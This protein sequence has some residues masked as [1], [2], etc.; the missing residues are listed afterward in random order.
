[1]KRGEIWTAS[2]GPDYAS[3]PRPVLIIQADPFDSTRSITVCPLTTSALEAPFVRLP[4]EPSADNGLRAPSRL[5][6]DKVTTLPRTKLAARIG[7]LSPRQMSDVN[8]A[9]L[10]FLGLVG[11][12]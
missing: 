3:K 5:M 1:M 10:V 12:G 4:I 6:I 8:R 2:G 7:H 11:S 9:L